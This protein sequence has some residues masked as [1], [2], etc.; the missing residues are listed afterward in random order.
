MKVQTRLNDP[1]KLAGLCNGRL[2]R[3]PPEILGADRSVLCNNVGL[4]LRLK[5]HCYEVRTR[6]GDNYIT[7][8][9]YDS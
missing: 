8:I 6:L 7:A 5:I 3:S 4:T 9:H 2:P 1:P